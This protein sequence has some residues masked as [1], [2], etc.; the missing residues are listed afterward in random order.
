MEVRENS[1]G[2]PGNMC[3]MCGVCR[4]PLLPHETALFRS[5]RG[6]LIQLHTRSGPVLVHWECASAFRTTSDLMRAVTGGMEHIDY[7]TE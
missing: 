2:A 5:G 3:E 4:K 6:N 1:S 7:L